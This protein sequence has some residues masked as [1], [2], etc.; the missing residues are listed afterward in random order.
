MQINGIVIIDRR[1]IFREGLARLLRDIPDIKEVNTCANEQEAP[2][3]IKKLK[4]DI[5]LI[6][7]D[8]D[9]HHIATTEHIQSLSPD[10][11]IIILSY[12]DQIND[13]LSAFKAGAQAYLSKDISLENLINNFSLVISGDMIIS[14]SAASCLLNEFIKRDDKTY[15]GKNDVYEILTKRETEVLELV[16]TGLTNKDIAENLK[17]SIHT[18]KAHLRNVTE[19]LHVHNR[20]QAV[21]KYR[22]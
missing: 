22:K 12:R 7:A 20:Q 14:S 11:K 1:E 15:E 5:V 13:I 16:A 2:V 21:T 9:S 18:V 17:I 4:P 19:K 10:V 6:V 8:P 3:K